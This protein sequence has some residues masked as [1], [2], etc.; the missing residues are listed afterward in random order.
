M[1]KELKTIEKEMP[2]RSSRYIGSSFMIRRIIQNNELTND[3]KIEKIQERQKREA[4]M[5]YDRANALRREVNEYRREISYLR[6]IN[7]ELKEKLSIQIPEECN[8][9]NATESFVNLRILINEMNETYSTS[10]FTSTALL[11]RKFIINIIYALSEKMNIKI[12]NSQVNLA[13]GNESEVF[14]RDEN[15][16][17]FNTA[18]K[19]LFYHRFLTTKDYELLDKLRDATNEFNHGVSIPKGIEDASKLYLT[20]K[21]LVESNFDTHN[22][23]SEEDEKEQTEEISDEFGE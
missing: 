14:I 17:T 1:E 10:L 9:E 19:W 12:F 4:G 7:N 15:S 13:V 21:G 6:E 16:F 8:Y 22:L 18:V 2:Q 11:S 20:I 23:Y 3:E 5:Y